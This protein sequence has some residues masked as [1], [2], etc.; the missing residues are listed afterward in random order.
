[1]PAT[2]PYPE[3]TTH[4]LYFKDN[5]DAAKPGL[6][7]AHL[8]SLADTFRSADQATAKPFRLDLGAASY[9]SE[10][11]PSDVFCGAVKNGT[12]NLANAEYALTGIV[13]PK[14][15]TR[16]ADVYP[17]VAAVVGSTYQNMTGAFFGNNALESVTLSATMTSVGKG[18]FAFC[19]GLT[20]LTIEGAGTSERFTIGQ[21]A[22]WNST[23]LKYISC[24]RTLPPVLT[25]Y[26][27]GTVNSSPFFGIGTSSG[28]GW[29][30]FTVPAATLSIY[31]AD[32]GWKTMIAEKN[33]RIW[34]SF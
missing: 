25:Y 4:T 1:M 23:S 14:N 20:S 19:R 3:N 27:N 34:A 31:Q 9:E 6:T 26:S 10:T 8:Q 17:A 33:N 7:K 24:E 30:T 29:V 16:I 21:N 22:F 2:L 15:N 18:A 32:S 13:F 12:F 11:F 28:I 5:A